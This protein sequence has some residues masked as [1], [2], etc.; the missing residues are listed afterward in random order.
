VEEEVEV[1][2]REGPGEEGAPGNREGGKWGA[3]DGELS[4]LHPEWSEEGPA[5]WE[6]EEEGVAQPEDTCRGRRYGAAL[7]LYEF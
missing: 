6:G 4:L 2:M 7:S 5:E 1:S 3:G